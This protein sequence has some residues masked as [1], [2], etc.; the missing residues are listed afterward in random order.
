MT[1]VDYYDKFDAGRASVGQIEDMK[2]Y[3]SQ[4]RKAIEDKDKFGL[5]LY[6]DIYPVFCAIYL[7]PI[8]N[9]DDYNYERAISG[10]LKRIKKEMDF[11]MVLNMGAFFLKKLYDSTN[12]LKKEYTKVSKLLRKLKRALTIFLLRLVSM[13]R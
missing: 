6:F 4:K 13:L 9:E 10:T 2:N 3:L 1:W 12:G 11:T 7:D 5:E 8:L